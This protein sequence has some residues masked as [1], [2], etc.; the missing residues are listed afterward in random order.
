MEMETSSVGSHEGV[1][2][3]DLGEDD[4]LEENGGLTSA[5]EPISLQPSD[6]CR[7]IT[8]DIPAIDVPAV[9]IPNIDIPVF[10]LSSLEPKFMPTMPIIYTNMFNLF[11][12]QGT[13]LPF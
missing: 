7:T 10:D 2:L 11:A 4:F 1:S 6:P 8:P 5:A 3:C 13:P 9:T 12:N